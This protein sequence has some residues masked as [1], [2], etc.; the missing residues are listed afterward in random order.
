MDIRYIRLGI[1]NAKATS[2]KAAFVEC[3]LLRRESH[4]QVLQLVTYTVHSCESS[5]RGSP[6][7]AGQGVRYP[8]FLNPPSKFTVQDATKN[9]AVGVCKIQIT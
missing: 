5:E 2:E 6:G 9:F 1:I 4:D 3:S 8:H 7:N